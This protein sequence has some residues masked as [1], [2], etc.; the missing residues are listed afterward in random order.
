MTRMSDVSRLGEMVNGFQRTCALLAMIETG[1]VERLQQGSASVE[2]L[3][4]ELKLDPLALERLL[5]AL[6]SL[7]LVEFGSPCWSLSALGA[8]LG[9]GSL[10][11]GIRAW[12]ELVNGEYLRA[13]GALGDCIR[14][15]QPSFPKLF[16]QSVW[17][18]RESN[19]ALNDAFQ[20]LTRGEQQ[21]AVSGLLR[22][23]RLEGVGSVMDVG[24]GQGQL[25]AGVLQAHPAMTGVLFDLPQALEGAESLLQASG[26]WSRTRLVA[27]SFLETRPE[28]VDL[29]LLKHVLHNWNDADSLRI[30]SQLAQGSPE[31]GKLVILENVLPEADCEIDL[32]QAMLDLHMLALHGGRERKL[33]EFEELLSASGWRLQRH[34]TTRVGVPQIMEAVRMS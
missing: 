22:Y 16:G 18:H 9:K 1:L 28:P 25:L 34:I 12:A 14:D 29:Y 19:P 15:G 17:Q 11:S 27:G 30:L 4:E 23:Y 33:T 5:R 20:R 13:W 32:A 3:A 21:R 6:G 26:V 24:G 31:G 7:G 10:G 2:C 8:V